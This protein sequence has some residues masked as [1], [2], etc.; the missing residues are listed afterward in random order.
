MLTGGYG[1]SRLRESMLGGVT[2]SILA[3]MTIPTLMSQQ[4]NKKESVPYHS[5]RHVIG[6][7]TF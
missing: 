6:N 1:H 4:V 3:S 7:T 5:I 2:R